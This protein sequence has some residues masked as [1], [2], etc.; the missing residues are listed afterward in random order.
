MLARA[1]VLLPIPSSAKIAQ[2]SLTDMTGDG[3]W[4][5]TSLGRLPQTA[6]SMASAAFLLRVDAAL[7]AG[8]LF[9]AALTESQSQIRGPTVPTASI[10]RWHGAEWV[11]EEAEPN[12]FVRRAVRLGPRANGRALLEGEIASGAKVVTVGARALLAA[13]L[14]PTSGSEEGAD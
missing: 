8:Q 9:Q 5:A 3:N 12:H 13:E 7:A 11:Y 14:T 1:Q 4:P 2:V 6:G 10:I